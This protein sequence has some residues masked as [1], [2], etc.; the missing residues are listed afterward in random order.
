MLPVLGSELQRARQ[1]D[2]QIAL[3]RAAAARAAGPVVRTERRARRFV[4][5][6]A[7]GL[8]RT[9]D[10]LEAFGRPQPECAPDVREAG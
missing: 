3:E 8:R 5:A 2:I 9:A 1:R 6:A 10:R 7:S 4:I